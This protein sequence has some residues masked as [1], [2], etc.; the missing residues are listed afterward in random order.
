[1]DSRCLDPKS[2]SVNQSDPNTGTKSKGNVS[3]LENCVLDG[4]QAFCFSVDAGIC[5]Q[6]LGYEE[7]PILNAC[8]VLWG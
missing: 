4:N 6:T 3:S 7:N 1:M 2:F 5:T 8:L